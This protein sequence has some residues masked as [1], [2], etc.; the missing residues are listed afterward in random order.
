MQ[1]RNKIVLALAPASLAVALLG[2]AAGAAED[3]PAPDD[4]TTTTT[5]V[6]TPPA[7][8]TPGEPIAPEEPSADAPGSP[9]T[10]APDA[11]TV[12]SGTVG[13]VAVVET[14]AAEAGLLDPQ[15]VPVHQVI[16]T[17]DPRQLIV[18]FQTGVAECYGLAR[19]E[20]LETDAEVTLGLFVGRR[21]PE[22]V[23]VALA[24]THATT[25]TLASPLGAR[26]VVDASATTD[27]SDPPTTDPTTTPPTVTEPTVATPPTVTEPTVT[28]PTVTTPTVTVTGSTPEPI[29]PA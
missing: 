4:A 8:A 16:A 26:A 19:T 11:P 27:P 25:V 5:L 28:T 7:P 24:E 13:A 12:P 10:T 18:T 1:R 14:R 20:V 23:C 21:D 29:L 3:Q 17:D 22:Q 15:P 2:V 6:T 9:D